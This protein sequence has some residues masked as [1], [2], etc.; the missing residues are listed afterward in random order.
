[1]QRRSLLAGR[2]ASVLA[3]GR[4][5][6]DEVTTAAFVHNVGLL[7]LRQA[8]PEELTEIMRSA[9]RTGTP[10]HLEEE[11][12]LGVTHAEI[13]AYLLGVWGLPFPIVE[14]VAFHHRPE[15]AFDGAGEVVALVHAVSALI[16]ERH[17]PGSDGRLDV[18][19]LRRCGYADEIALW[20]ECAAQVLDG[21]ES[22]EV[23]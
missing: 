19:F 16:D 14:A 5:H 23:A 6:A 4:Q 3:K 17:E 7:V 18:D 11:R 10:L 21:M 20:R 9:E 1:M 13:G 15:L 22:T 2:L 8:L 12:L